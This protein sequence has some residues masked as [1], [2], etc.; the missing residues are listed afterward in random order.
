MLEA[1]E[2]ELD[3]QND[4]NA[5]DPSAGAIK[6]DEVEKTDVL[7]KEDEESEAEEDEDEL[8]F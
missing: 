7:A 5:D 4:E 1:Q 8:L 2:E 6:P 3:H